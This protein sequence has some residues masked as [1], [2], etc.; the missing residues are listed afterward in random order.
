MV[1]KRKRPLGVFICLVPGHLDPPCG[2]NGP[3]TDEWCR[4]ASN[5]EVEGRVAWTGLDSLLRPNHCVS[6][7]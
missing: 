3:K 5:E 4:A 1:S 6:E 2:K 7:D